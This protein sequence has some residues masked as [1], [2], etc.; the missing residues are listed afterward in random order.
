MSRFV[1]AALATACALAAPPAHAQF[2]GRLDYTLSGMPGPHG[3]EGAAAAR[4]GTKDARM[5]LYVSA[6]GARSEMTASL[7]DGKGGTRSTRLVVIYKASEPKKTIMLN[8]AQRTYAVMEHDEVPRAP[9][10][11]GKV[12]RIGSDRV[13]GYACDKV[14]VT[15][16]SGDGHQEVC[17]TKELGKM[18]ILARM[19]A[20]DDEDVLGQLRRAGLDGVPVATR[21]FDEDGKPGVSMLLTAAKRQVVPASMFAVPA[22]YTETGMAGVMA[23]PEQAKQ[24]DAAMKEMQERMK[25]MPPEQRKQME[26]MLKRMGGAGK[27]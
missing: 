3:P 11:G 7:P 8:E 23:S 25:K 9:R 17:V 10:A 6:A 21:A 24:M 18:S 13:A 27:N 2:Q 15:L 1:V 16:E 19:T 14:R 22:G 4:E 20:E 12:E 26:E 5:T